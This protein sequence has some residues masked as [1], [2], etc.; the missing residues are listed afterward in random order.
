MQKYVGGP[1]VVK[2]M[3]RMLE[4][5]LDKGSK[6]IY[7]NIWRQESVIRKILSSSMVIP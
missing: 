2:T 1:S 4:D 3:L 7:Q 5:V 6:T